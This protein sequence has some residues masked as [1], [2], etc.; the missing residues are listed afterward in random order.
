M[1]VRRMRQSCPWR[2]GGGTAPHVLNIDRRLSREVSLTAC[3][4]NPRGVPAVT[5]ERKLGE[6]PQPGW[7]R[8]RRNLLSLP[9]TEPQFL[10]Y[11]ACRVVTT[12]T[13]VCRSTENSHHCVTNTSYGSWKERI[14]EEGILLWVQEMGQSCTMETGEAQ[15]KNKEQSAEKQRIL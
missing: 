6:A 11:P 14:Y 8:W 7:T 13:D 12:S 3:S 10:G 2:V 5:N 1:C 9:G 15:T 4:L